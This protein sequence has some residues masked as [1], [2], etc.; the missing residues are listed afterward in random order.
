MADTRRIRSAPGLLVTVSVA[1]PHN[2]KSEGLEKILPKKGEK[3]I[4]IT[5]A[6][7]YVNN[8]PHLGNIIGSTL[9]ADVYSRYSRSRNR[10]TLYI[11]GTDEYGTAT[12]TKALSEGCTPQELCDKFHVVHKDVYEWFEIGFDYFGRT[13]TPAQTEIAQDIFLKLNENDCLQ[14]QDMV[15]LFCESCTRFLADRFVEGTCP[16]CG[17]DDARGDQCDK[18]GQ[19]QNPAELIKPRCK[20]CS[21][22][23]VQR[24]SRHMFVRLDAITPRLAPWI[25]KSKEK[26]KWSNNGVVITE[27]WLKEGLR[28]RCITRDMKWGVPVPLDGFRDKVLYVWFDAPIGYPSITANYTKDWEQW[29]KNPDE[30]DLY[31][32]MGKDNVPF[33]TVMFPA[34]LIGSGD[35][36]TLLHHIN[37]TEYLNYESGKF[38]KS[39]NV[40]VFGNNAKDTGIAPSV[41]RYYLLSNRPEV[42][43]SVFTWSDFVAKNNGELLNNLGNMVNR[44]L[45]FIANNCDRT[46][47]GPADVEGGT[48]ALEDETS[49]EGIFVMGVNKA[50]EDYIAAMEAVKIRNGLMAAMTLSQRTNEFVQ[51]NKLDNSLLKSDPERCARVLLLA[52]NA[53]YAV[54]TLIE[55][56]M[57]STAQSILEQLNAPARSV[58]EAL[59]ID[60]LPGHKIG[61]PKALF[62]RID[63]SKKVEE[64][65]AAYGGQ[66]EEGAAPVAKLGKKKA[67]KAARLA[68]EQA[69]KAA[70]AKVPETPEVMALK[71]QIVVQGD[72]VKA[73]KTGAE[74]GDVEA[75]VAALKKLK[76]DW[77]T[78]IAS[79]AQ[80]DIKP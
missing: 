34:Y 6:L 22:P 67:G 62:S 53:I 12:E 40:G 23:P 50:L 37:T 68:A 25:E 9:S 26:G 13:T 41:W 21:K 66:P 36:W 70:E 73:L 24:S 16:K 60:L 11:C 17:Y 19:L 45:K 8:T 32:F 76:S 30:V 72:K 65:R 69:A 64:W 7:P 58:P 28:P 4:L 27:S 42:S 3:N 15:Q 5:S 54:S 33:H 74:V 31:Q 39:R 35:N 2:S 59:S 78:L 38:S 1:D 46:L 44:V 20:L 51:A 52:A 47:R 61:T 55:P 80:V 14:A 48:V 77:D 75:E 18:C 79:F 56:F 63:A 43:D 10:N 29:W 57:P 49:L 71:A